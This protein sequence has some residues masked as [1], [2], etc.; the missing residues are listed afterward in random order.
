[1]M[2]PGAA[3]LL[4]DLGRGGRGALKL[5]ISRLKDVHRP[6][7]S[8][9]WTGE[10]EELLR[11]AEYRVLELEP[12][13]VRLLRIRAV[14]HILLHREEG[15]LNSPYFTAHVSEVTGLSRDRAIKHVWSFAPCVFADASDSYLRYLFCGLENSGCGCLV[16]PDWASR[17]MDRD[18]YGA[19]STVHGMIQGSDL[20]FGKISFC[21]L[22]LAPEEDHALFCGDSAALP[23]YLCAENLLGMKTWPASIAATGCLKDGRISGVG[24]IEQKMERA[25]KEGLGFFLYPAGNRALAPERSY[26]LFCIQVEEPC[27]ALLA[28][29]LGRLKVEMADDILRCLTSAESFVAFCKHLPDACL[30]IVTGEVRQLA[31]RVMDSP[32][33]FKSFV[34]NFQTM[35]ESSRYTLAAFLSSVFNPFIEGDSTLDSVLKTR[36]FCAN[37]ELA[38]HTGHVELSD[39]WVGKAGECMGE[40]VKKPEGR[41]IRRW[42]ENHRFVG[43]RH[44]GYDFRPE[45]IRGFA[46]LVE[47]AEHMFLLETEGIE[48]ASDPA[49][50]AIYGTM[51]QHYGFCGPEFLGETL[52][53][54]KKAMKRFGGVYG[55]RAPSEGRENFLRQYNHLA[56]AFLDAGKWAEAERSLLFYLE[57]PS[58]ESVVQALDGLSEWEHALVARFMAD[59]GTPEQVC[60]CVDFVRTRG[61]ACVVLK[62]PWQLWRHNMA[63]C[64]WRAG[65]K[66]LAR[67]LAVASLALCE[68]KDA[69]VTMNV[70]ALLPL[71][72]LWANGLADEKDLALSFRNAVD[73][74]LAL[75]PRHFSILNPEDFKGTLDAV[76]LNPAA[77]FPFSYR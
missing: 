12:R 77:F 58:L 46:D 26:P 75:N 48:G 54:S 25:K 35:V 56:Y 67:S 18:F 44:N 32:E 34:M 10:A 14:S 27:H 65:E 60:A 33:L 74:A 28:F 5:G 61:A 19:V 17:L 71:A 13:A 37:L 64:S 40:A 39:Y 22:P 6:M 36:W 43:A 30:G 2:E 62:H 23:V 16:I 9:V 63:R 4:H 52:R 57:Q 72:F 50:G 76:R 3:V 38:N 29:E 20:A 49:L 59:A 7:L 31:P 51:A 41:E 73:K 21:C 69:G 45:L 42:F 1:M 24:F 53:F 47:K 55:K 11:L 68:S 15:W 8:D 70:M 66:D